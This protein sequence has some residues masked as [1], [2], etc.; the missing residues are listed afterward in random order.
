MKSVQ[1]GRKSTFVTGPVTGCDGFCDGLAFRKCLMDNM[2]DGVTAQYPWTA[3]IR[4]ISAL[5]SPLA[6]PPEPAKRTDKRA[7]NRAKSC[8]NQI[9]A[10]QDWRRKARLYWLFGK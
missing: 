3:T 7:A 1:D 8:Q 5:N 6:M 9:C 4:R 10:L 2:C